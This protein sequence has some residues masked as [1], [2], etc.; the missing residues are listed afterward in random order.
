MQHEWKLDG[1]MRKDAGDGELYE[2]KRHFL[3]RRKQPVREHAGPGDDLPDGADHEKRKRIAPDRTP[4][5]FRARS[6][7]S[8]V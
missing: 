3:Q 7:V 5:R 1:V 8:G 4:T 6:Y 2:G